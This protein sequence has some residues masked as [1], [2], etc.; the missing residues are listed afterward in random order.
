MRK[1]AWVVSAILLAAAGSPAAQDGVTLVTASR[2]HTMDTARPMA[3][4]M[5]YGADGRIL[6]VGQADALAKQYPRARRV[7]VG[8]ATVVPGLI[9]AH[10]HI[11]GLGLAMLSADLVGTRDKAGILQR[12]RVHE[13]TLKPGEWLVG[14][15]WDQNDWPQ[16]RFPNAADLDAAF[17]DRPVWLSRVDGH[18]GWANSAAIRAVRRDLSGDWQPDGG[19]IDRDAAGKPTGLFIDNAMLLVEQARPAM[20]EATAEHALEIAMRAAAE[21]GLTGVHDAGI[22]LAELGRYQRLAD[23]GRMPLRIS[24]MADGD[25]AALESLCRNGLYRHPSGRLQMRA[26]KLYADGALGS[27]GAAML[28]DYSD[29][30][31]NRG[32]MVMS[33]AQLAAATAKAKRCG[34]QVATHAIGDR[35]NREALDAYATALGTDAA[36]DHRWRIE[37][38]QILSAQDLPR[39]AG[40]RVIAS[41]QPT[42]ATSDMPWAEDRVGAQRIAG[43]YAWRQLRDSGARLALGSDFPVERVDPRLGLQAATTRADGE[44]KPVGGWFPGEKLTA[45]EALRGFTLDAAHAGFAEAEVGSLVAGKRAD[46]VVLAAD[47]LASPEA[48]LKEIA[49]LATYV[50]GKPVFE[51]A[52]GR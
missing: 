21:Q 7:D 10:A 25:S 20:S 42:H 30:H 51:A 32:L 43:A 26:V 45:F 16:Q 40:L 4:A 8:N 1:L 46:F 33:P 41:M 3:T 39:L 5:A 49:V 47:P 24:A 31:G 36:S 22:T 38:A 13:Q 35:G 12:L 6:A 9:D 37:H 15:G 23:R 48:R 14:G 28:E 17:P 34:V 27:R 18:A 52:S 19:R 44:G 2:I 11:G 50:D 29:D